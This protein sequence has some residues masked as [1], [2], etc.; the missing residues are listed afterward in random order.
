M[1]QAGSANLRPISL[2]RFESAVASTGAQRRGEAVPVKND[3][4]QIEISTVPSMPVLIDGEPIYREVPHTSLMR[5]MNT[6]PLLLRDASGTYYL[7]VFDGWM[8]APSLTGKWTVAA[9]VPSAC[10]IALKAA[11]EQKAVDLLVGGDPKDPRSAPSLKTQAPRIFVTT[12]PTELLV[13]EGQPK[14]L[15][16][17]G[18]KLMYASNTTG[19]VFVDADNRKAYVLVA[20]RWCAGPSTLT[21]PWAFVPGDKLPDDFR[22]IPDDSPVENVKASIPGT[23]QAEEA[24]VANS[25]PQTAM[26]KRS[27]A[28]FTPA[29]DSEPRLEP[30]EGTQLR[31]VVN[32]SLPIVAVGTPT[33]Y[34]GVQNAVW[35]VSSSLDGPWLVATSV[36]AAVYSI[37][38]SSPLHYITYV[39]VYDYTPDY[40]IV[41]YTPGYSGVYVSDGC[42][43]YGTGFYYQPWIGTVWY[44]QP[45]TYGFGAAIAYARW[46]G[47]YA[48]FGFGW[49]WGAATAALGWGWGPY[50]W[51]G[52]YGWGAYYPWT[53]AGGAIAWGAH[54]GVGVWG[55]GYF[56]GTTGNIY[57]RWGATT[58]VTRTAGGYN[59]WTGNQWA[60]QV[61]RAYNSRT[62]VAAAGE[63]GAIGNVYTGDYAAGA[64]GAAEN[65]RRTETTGPVNTA[66]GSQ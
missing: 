24:I 46:A 34:F 65:T 19:R 29:F 1:I 17:G 47:W 36:P 25:I 3:P 12:K 63:R 64:R 51:W 9:S 45:V 42:I 6:R 5:V 18:T 21:G 35:F 40:V 27:T 13:F 52:G 59:A 8:Q 11:I 31:W 61:G 22:K 41:G 14:F 10:D 53:Y 58:A 7:K 16:I 62:G 37:P 66:A 30:I 39:R 28:T 44:G 43:V 33:E 48:G 15:P 32:A 57:Q 49:T 55:P 38:V 26:V 2:E 23:E 56:A 20:G 60:G 50:P 54:G 4:P